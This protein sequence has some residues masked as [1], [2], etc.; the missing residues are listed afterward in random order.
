MASAEDLALISLRQALCSP[1]GQTTEKTVAAVEQ[2][3]EALGFRATVF[4]RWGELTV[5]VDNDTGSHYEI[6]AVEPVGV[7]MSKVAATVS[8][9]DKVCAGRIDTE[10]AR[11]AFEAVT[12][13][14]RGAVPVGLRR[15]IGDRRP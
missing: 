13:F 1:N 12:R 10:A 2:L 8:V 7:D 11:S 5:R 14:P 3:A 4:P 6:I 9:I 15:A